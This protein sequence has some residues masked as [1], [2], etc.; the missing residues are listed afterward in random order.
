MAQ[1]NAPKQAPKE[2]Q[3]GRNSGLK[4]INTTVLKLNVTHSGKTVRLMF[5]NEA[6]FG[7]INKPKYC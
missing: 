3:R 6:G 2:G 7:R 4:K 1:S 5:Q